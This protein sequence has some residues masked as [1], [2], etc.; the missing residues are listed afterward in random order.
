[1]ATDVKSSSGDDISSLLTK[2]NN[3]YSALTLIYSGIGGISDT[4]P[5][6]ASFK[7]LPVDKQN[8]VLDAIYQFQCEI[9]TIIGMLNNGIKSLE[10]GNMPV[11]TLPPCT[12]PPWG[13]T[14]DNTS[15]IYD[16]W[17]ALRPLIV[18]MIGKY[19][20]TDSIEKIVAISV[21]SKSDALIKAIEDIIYVLE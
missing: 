21:L 5:N 11:S 2:W 3:I 15:I 4:L 12:I 1:M 10:S 6:A 13:N 17:D 19:Y 7:K 20:K 16:I 9:Y 18:G 14:P 8:K